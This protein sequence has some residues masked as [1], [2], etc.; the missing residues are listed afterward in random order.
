MIFRNAM[1]AAKRQDAVWTN[2]SLP[3]GRGACAPR[4][5]CL[6]PASAFN[7][8]SRVEWRSPVYAAALLFLS[9]AGLSS[10]G[11]EVKKDDWLKD[12]ESIAE[13]IQGI[14][15]EE[16]KLKYSVDAHEATIQTLDTNI[17]TLDANMQSL[18]ANLKALD[19][20]IQTLDANMK[21]IDGRLQA[22]EQVSAGQLVKIREMSASI[23]KS[24]KKRPASAGGKKGRRAV[25]GKAARKKRPE[26]IKAPARLAA[27]AVKKASPVVVVA[28][29]EK[30][31]YTAAYLALKSGHYKESS[32][33]FRLLLEQYPKGE[34]ADQAWYWL[35]E[36]S[37][38][39]HDN[40]KAIKA[41]KYVATHYLNSVKHAA[42][43]FKLGQ[44]LQSLNRHKE[45]AGFY[46]QLIN[47]HGDSSIAEQARAALAEIRKAEREK[48]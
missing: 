45:A 20:N 32:Q 21:A 10:C 12:R 14:D 31:S 7:I 39:Q 35:G 33:A 46:T 42:A 25:V 29:A 41:F 36:S 9:V 19:T 18:D 11:N 3:A 23:R 44:V 27:P 2:Y 40:D 30:N 43:L 26:I 34:Y 5:K 22:L 37:Y 28:E 8:G 13:S 15:A 47:K 17:R 4:I 6:H 1:Q 38:A 48:K 24:K 16:K